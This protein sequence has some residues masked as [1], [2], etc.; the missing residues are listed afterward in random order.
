MAIRD[1]RENKQSLAKFVRGRA[2]EGAGP[3][4]MTR[5]LRSSNVASVGYDEATRTLYVEFLAVHPR[6]GR[7]Q[8]KRLKPGSTVIYRY[9]NV[10]ANII[11]Q[12]LHAPS[13]GHYFWI[14]VRG[15]YR[16]MKL[17]RKGWR[18]PVGG[19]RAPKRRPGHATFKRK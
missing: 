15:R 19:H 4:V 1:P 5:T 17:G 2:A 16:Y 8:P 7:M 6:R 12:L 14:R 10:P 9:F 13:V 18:G 3:V 11:K